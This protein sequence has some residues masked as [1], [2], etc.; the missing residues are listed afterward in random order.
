MKASRIKPTS[1]TAQPEERVSFDVEQAY[2]R[3]VHQGAHWACALIERGEHIVDVRKWIDRTLW[4][5]R[6]G[7]KRKRRK[8]DN[9]A[10]AIPT[11]GIRKG[12]LM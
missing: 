6:F 5:W 12:T 3:G 1:D 2:R 9:T 4:D 8:R 11:P 10:I 7:L